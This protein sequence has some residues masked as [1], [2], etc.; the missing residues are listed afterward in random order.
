M[1][2]LLALAVLCLAASFAWAQAALPGFPGGSALPPGEP[3]PMGM[4]HMPVLPEEPALTR[5]TVTAQPAP[6]PALKYRFL[7]TLSERTPGNAAL[8]YYQA[9]QLLPKDENDGINSYLETPLSELP[10]EEVAS[11]LDDHAHALRLV[12][13]G[14]TREH[15]YFGSELSEGMHRILPSVQEY[16][17]LGRALSVRARLEIARGQFDRAI[18]TIGVGM[19]LGQHVSQGGPGLLNVL[20]GMSIQSVVLARVEDLAQRGGPNLYWAL[21]TLPRPMADFWPAKDW[22][23]QWVLAGYPEFQRALGSPMGASEGTALLEQLIEMRELATSLGPPKG[24]PNRLQA[25]VLGTVYYEKAK[26]TLIQRG[27]SK[28]EVEAM[29]AGQVVTVYFLQDYFH[30]RD[31]LTKWFVLPY[32]KAREKL[33][34]VDD[35]FMAW[36][37]AGGSQNPFSTVLPSSGRHSSLIQAKHERTRAILQTIEA[38]RAHAAKHGR[39]PATL[40]QLEL[41]APDDPITGKPFE[42]STEEKS[43]TLVGPEPEGE[44]LRQRVR[45][46]V[47]I[48]DAQARP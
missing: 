13:I 6:D 7:P 10:L 45:Y 24:S 19:T 33:K 43:F 32:P 31:E 23:R 14:A 9:L 38:I 11:F 5:I 48:A 15:A 16:R 3:G 39:T 40:D 1:R 37:G 36:Y 29:P 30:W 47:K 8:L 42:Y 17:A 21:A 34:Q 20:V 18:R 25:A 22:D 44:S 12:E 35:A 26:K 27:R 46:E 41:P 28:E 4:P 2:H